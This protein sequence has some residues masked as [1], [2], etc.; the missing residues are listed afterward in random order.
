VTTDNT[1]GARFNDGT[2]IKSHPFPF[3]FTYIVGNK[4]K[5]ISGNNIKRVAD[6]DILSKLKSFQL[7]K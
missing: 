1:L 3:K 7:M 6:K 5:Q 2:N 4:S